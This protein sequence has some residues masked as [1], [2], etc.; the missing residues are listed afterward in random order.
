MATLE[1]D[2]DGGLE[3]NWLLEGGTAELLAGMTLLV[4]DNAPHLCDDDG[5]AQV[6]THADPAEFERLSAAYVAAGERE[7]ALRTQLA[8]TQALLRTQDDLL[9]QAYQHD[10][11]TPLK[12]EIRAAALPAS[13]EP[14]APLPPVDGDLLP[15]INSKVLIHLGREDKWVE[16]TVVGY[17]AWGSH[18][19]D[20]NVHR[21]FVRVRDAEGCLNARL[22][23]DIRP[24][25]LELKP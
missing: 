4:A 22:L 11:G 13:A 10:I 3:P 6:Y 20:Q 17:Y 8:Q 25:T 9:S 21:V 5:S 24:V 19:L 16:H 23:N 7:H 12:R 18:G 15:P 2:G 1:E 14:S